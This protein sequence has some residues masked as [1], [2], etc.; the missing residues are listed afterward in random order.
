RQFA[1]MPNCAV[2]TFPPLELERDNLLVLALF[3]NFSGHF[4][5][6]DE[7]VAARHVLAIGKHKHVTEGRGLT[8][9]DVE[10]IHI[11]R[12]AFRDAKLSAASLDNCVSHKPFSKEKKPPKVPQMAG[13]GKRKTRFE[14]RRILAPE[15]L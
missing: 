3:D 12:V 2:I 8:R 5:S 13:L 9:I 6:G 14:L 7:R 10:K 15:A 11:D 1:A 4:C